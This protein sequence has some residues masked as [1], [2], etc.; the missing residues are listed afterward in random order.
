MKNILF[1]DI[2]GVI[3]CSYDHWNWGSNNNTFDVPLVQNLNL[4]CDQADFKIVITSTWRKEHMSG[5][6]HLPEVFKN[7]G[8]ADLK[9]F[10]RRWMTP[11]LDESRE[12]EILSWID[13]WGEPI[14]KIV[15]LDDQPIGPKLDKYLVKTSVAQGLVPSVVDFVVDAFNED[16]AYLYKEED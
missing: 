6:L 14:D 9:F 4:I 2:D 3:K 1:L 7:S 15:I 16:D 8:F 10:H 11:N 13:Q 12:N 5:R